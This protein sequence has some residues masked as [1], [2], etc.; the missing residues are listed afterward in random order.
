MP[1]IAVA[2]SSVTVM[3]AGKVLTGASLTAATLMVTVS[4]ST[5]VP[6]EPVLPP[7]LV[8]IVSVAAPL[9]LAVGT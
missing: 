4:M 5:S 1:V 6:P 7:S 8:A 3:D 9:K 2:T